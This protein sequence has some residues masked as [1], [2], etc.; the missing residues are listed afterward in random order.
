MKKNV[1]LLCGVF[2]IVFIVLGFIP[3]RPSITI[4]NNTSERLYLSSSEGVHD[5]EPDPE[6]VERIMKVRPEVIEAGGTIQITP[7]FIF[8]MKNNIEFDVGWLTGGRYAY[9]ATG[10]GGQN[11]IFSSATGTCSISLVIWE[12]YNNYSMENKKKDFCIKK[13]SPLKDRYQ[14]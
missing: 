10:G 8:L 11:F 12:G 1:L 4:K 6:E 7:S 14:Q 3:L 2:L 13:I 5:I 9:K